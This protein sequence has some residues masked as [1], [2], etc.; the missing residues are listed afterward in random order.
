MD[1]HYPFCYAPRSFP[2]NY[3]HFDTLT[4]TLLNLEGHSGI[5]ASAERSNSPASTARNGSNGSRSSE[6]ETMGQDSAQKGKKQYDKW[7]NEEQI[8]GK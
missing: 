7:S 8:N 2:M 5:L 6:V 1:G 4:Q 3:Q